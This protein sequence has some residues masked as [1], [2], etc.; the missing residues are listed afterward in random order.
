MQPAEKFA[1]ALAILTGRLRFEERGR[2]A[3]KVGMFSLNVSDRTEETSQLES[4]TSL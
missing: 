2:K 3:G 1:P 4:V